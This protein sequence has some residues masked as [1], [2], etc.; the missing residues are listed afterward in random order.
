M[1]SVG[2]GTLSNTSN[3]L[4]RGE[5]RVT[6]IQ[7]RGNGQL[8]RQLREKYN[9]EL[10]SS[11]GN[12]IQNRPRTI[13]GEKVTMYEIGSEGNVEYEGTF[14]YYSDGGKEIVNIRRVRR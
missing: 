13:N 8:A 10:E 4:A 3:E 2:N 1:G 14:N 12:D 6:G 7:E 9:L 11:D 5:G